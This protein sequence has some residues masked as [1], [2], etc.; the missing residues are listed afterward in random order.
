MGAGVV[1]SGISVMS[2]KVELSSV[3]TRY[4]NGPLVLEGTGLGVG[5]GRFHSVIGPSGCGKST[6]L[7]LVAGLLRPVEGSVRVGERDPCHSGAEQ[8]GFVFQEPTLMPWLDVVANI[9]LPL[10][11]RGVARHEREERAREIAVGLGLGDCLAYY[12]RQLSGGMRMRVSLAR[13]L[14]TSPGLMLFDEPFAGLDSIR[15]D[16]IGEEL[17]D[18]WSRDGWTAL[19]VTHNV[20]EA[21]FLSEK[22]HVMG[23]KP[24]RLVGEYEVPLPYPRTPDM[25]R[26]RAFQHVVAEVTEGLRGVSVA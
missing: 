3:S 2:V 19:F 7:R 9:A 16:S 14:A 26:D 8:T 20:A 22:V 1:L 11:L 6:L 13:A 5:S 10:R 15:R 23:G 4:E 18:V 17:L 24:G 12:P 25:R 21:V